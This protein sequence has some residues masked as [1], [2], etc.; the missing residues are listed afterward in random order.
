MKSTIRRAEEADLDAVMAAVPA[1]VAAMNAA[2]NDQ[3]GAHY[4]LRAH[5]TQDL[6]ENSLFVDDEAGQIRGFAVLNLEEPEEYDELPWSQGRPALVVHRLAVVQTF[7]RRGVA[8]GLF[9][10]SE[11]RARLLGLKSLRSDTS[12]RNPAMNALFARRGWKRVGGIRFSDATVDFG[13]WEKVL[14]G[15]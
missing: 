2:G 14:G 4:P 10:F 11:E 12:D 3:W 8:D 7:H 5:F 1:L 15:D 6:A 13:A 9:A